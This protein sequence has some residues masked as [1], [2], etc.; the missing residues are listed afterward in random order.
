M[1]VF[2][3]GLTLNNNP[4]SF[5]LPNC[6]YC[7]CCRPRIENTTLL[8][9]VWYWVCLGAGRFGKSAWGCRLKSRYCHCITLDCYF[10]GAGSTFLDAYCNFTYF[11]VQVFGVTWHISM[12]LV[13]EFLEFLVV[14]V[15]YCFPMPF[16]GAVV[17]MHYQLMR[18][19]FCCWITW[20]Y[21][22]FVVWQQY[23]LKYAILWIQ[24]KST[25]MGG[26][27]LLLSLLRHR[28]S[29]KAQKG[30]QDMKEE[31][32]WRLLWTSISWFLLKLKLC[33]TFYELSCT[34]FHA[35]MSLF[36]LF[37]DSRIID[38]WLFLTIFTCR[39]RAENAGKFPSI[40]DAQRQVGG[41]F[42]VVRDI[43]LELEYKS[44]THSS[45]SV[46]ET[47][48]EK[49]FDDSKHPTTKSA[50]VSSGNI[51]IAKYN[52]I[53]YGSQ[54]VDLNDK[55]SVNAG[56]EHHEGKRETRI[57]CGERRLFE[58]VE[59]MS[60]SVSIT[61]TAIFSYEYIIYSRFTWLGYE[62]C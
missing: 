5:I 12:W 34:V 2:K 4:W 36:Q 43:M 44:R 24:L 13:F 33:L 9:Y 61:L 59:I 22:Y 3:G 18:Y 7:P 58:E 27:M 11:F 51:E 42:Y 45:N 16:F 26:H 25:G 56:Y 47:L 14:S 55:E 57:S 15:D 10:W 46:D 20:L 1:E 30:F 54:S 62:F 29:R 35:G 8:F 39:Y 48:V 28:M 32:W 49:Q 38:T 60:T 53:Q 17:V 6:K 50:S 23:P 52:S 31:L 40:S 21:I 37:R 19:W 41:S